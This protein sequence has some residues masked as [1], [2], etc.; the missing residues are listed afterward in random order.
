M[1]QALSMSLPISLFCFVFLDD[2]FRGGAY[3]GG[4]MAYWGNASLPSGTNNSFAKANVPAQKIP[5]WHFSSILLVHR[6]E[7]AFGSHAIFCAILQDTPDS[8]D[9]AEGVC[10]CRVGVRFVD[11]SEHFSTRTLI[12]HVTL[13][14]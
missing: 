1:V 14:E 2:H 12:L 4:H 9:E 13:H 5:T 7:P 3:F 8:D 10:F 6:D 11:C